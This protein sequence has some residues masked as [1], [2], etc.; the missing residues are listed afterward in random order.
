M[1][2]LWMNTI[3]RGKAIRSEN[4]DGLQAWNDMKNTLPSN[5]CVVWK[6]ITMKYYSDLRELGVTGDDGDEK[7]ENW[8]PN[9]FL[10]QLGRI[11]KNNPRGGNVVRLCQIAYNI[12]Q[13]SAEL[14]K[15]H[16]SG[17][18]VYTADMKR[19]FYKH[20]LGELNSYV[21]QSEI[22]K[23]NAKLTWPK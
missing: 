1:E 17:I 12:G 18:S 8:A 13:L 6:K 9:H 2:A 14:D 4:K 11:I 3:A 22:E 5:E 15:E 10:L 19:Y 20:G 23:M 7:N 21:E 16:L